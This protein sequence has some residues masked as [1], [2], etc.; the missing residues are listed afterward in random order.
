MSKDKEIIKVDPDTDQVMCDGG[1]G[2]L[3]H[4]NVW[5]S[6]D[7]KTHVVCHYC[8]RQFVKAS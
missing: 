2:P 3:G 4:P 5:Y 7:K 1:A 8:G 6:F